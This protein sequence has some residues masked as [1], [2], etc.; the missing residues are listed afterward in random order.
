MKAWG[1]TD[2]GLVREENEDA[3]AIG[4]DGGWQWAVVCD[5]MGGTSGG[6]VAS[7]TAVSAFVEQLHEL[8]RPGMGVKE[9]R[10]AMF[11]G[12]TMANLAI[13]QAAVVDPTLEKMGTTL[14][15]AVCGEDKVLCCNVGDSRA[16][17]ITPGGI[18]Q[19]TRDHSVVQ[20]MVDSG[21]ITAAE[22]KHHPSRNL[23]TRALGPDAKVRADIF[24]EP[25][26]KGEYILLCTDGLVNTVSEQEML[27]EAIHSEDVEGCLERLLQIAKDN[28]APDNVTVVLLQN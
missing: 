25:W 26:Q 19:I 27:F 7:M 9:R 13:R 10:H 16:Y 6:H 14:V 22:A 3:F 5:G 23:I 24:E 15:G 21:Q 17:H 18:S 12:V 28:G 11:R 20:N 1:I 4:C 2:T 8:L